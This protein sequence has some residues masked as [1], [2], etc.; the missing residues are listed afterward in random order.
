MGARCC[1]SFPTCSG[2]R[3]MPCPK[4]EPSRF[5]YRS[6]QNRLTSPWP[7][8]ARASGRSIWRRSS[9]RSLRPGKR[10]AMALVSRFRNG[11]SKIIRQDHDS[12]QRPPG[13]ARDC[14]QDHTSGLKTEGL[15]IHHRQFM[16]VRAV[17]T[18]LASFTPLLSY[19]LLASLPCFWNPACEAAAYVVLSSRIFSK[20]RFSRAT[21]RPAAKMILGATCTVRYWLT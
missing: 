4:Q 16:R 13:E 14:T 15:A 10:P 9:I 3:L 8:P 2:M 21:T 5:G 1:R 12:Q 6:G 11:S 17:I 19:F 7:T 20:R 18:R